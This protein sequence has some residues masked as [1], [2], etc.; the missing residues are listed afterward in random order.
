MATT[1]V[2]G[3][4]PATFEDAGG[5]TQ[6]LAAFCTT[7]KQCAL[8][9]SRGKRM[10]SVA[11]PSMM[12]G[13]SITYCANGPQNCRRPTTSGRTPVSQRQKRS[14]RRKKTGRSQQP[15][16]SKH[17][18]QLTG[19]AADQGRLEDHALSGF[20][21]DPKVGAP[22]NPHSLPRPAS[23]APNRGAAAKDNKF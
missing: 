12:W 2:Y 5:A 20:C 4:Q 1:A 3:L 22:R 17:G 19:A 14:G 23:H 16:L 8:L 21:T 7:P 10:V 15:R 18:S 9:D 6:P 11:G 13:M